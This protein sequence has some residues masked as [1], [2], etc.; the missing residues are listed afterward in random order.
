MTQ[1]GNY[2]WLSDERYEKAKG[3]T[4]LQIA[5]ILGVFDQYGM[6]VEIPGAVEAIMEVVEQSWQVVRGKDKPIQA[7]NFR[8]RE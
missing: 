5:V 3:K 2:N 7:R 6:G 8:R 4:Q 1:G